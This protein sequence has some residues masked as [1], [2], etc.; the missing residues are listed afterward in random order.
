MPLPWQPR[1]VQ[2]AGIL[3]LK[4]PPTTAPLPFSSY[5]MFNP[6]LHHFRHNLIFTSHTTGGD[7]RKKERQLQE[8]RHLSMVHSRPS[9]A[10]GIL[11]I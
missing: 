5:C 3:P 8:T 9:T 11:D 6:H 1:L 7:K 2:Y 10:K 4:N